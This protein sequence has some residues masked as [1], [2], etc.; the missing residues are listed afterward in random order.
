[1][2]GRPRVQDAQGKS[3][4]L[5]LLAAVTRKRPRGRPRNRWGD[6]MPDIAWLCFDLVAADLSEDAETVRYFES[7]WGC[8]PATVPR[9]KAGGKIIE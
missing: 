4:R 5:V 8:C 1:M 9:G 7:S 2:M 3:A 6:R